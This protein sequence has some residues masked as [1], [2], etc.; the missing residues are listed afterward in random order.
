LFPADLLAERRTI[1]EQ[2]R[3]KLLSRFRAHGLLGTSGQG[4]IWLGLGAGADR[5]RLRAELLYDGTITAV[6]VEDLK[7]ERFVVTD[8]LSLI[9]QAELEVERG[10][11]PNGQPP[12]AAFLAPLDPL[13]W[14]RQVLRPLFGFDYVWEVYVP[15]AK[16]RWGYYVLP[17]WFGDR[18]VGRIEPR[19][20]RQAKALRVLGVWWEDGF[21][22]LGEEGFVEA[23]ADALDAHRRFG[24][25]KTV[26]LPRTGRLRAFMA[27][28]KTALGA[29]PPAG[30]PPVEGAA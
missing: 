16:R 3:H 4:E 28:V 2:R 24:D 9:D 19:I 1:D 11:P 10:V 5:P 30:R 20:D 13:V 22:P 21:D 27:A 12:G 15:A 18:F 23:F 26:V 17:I 6:A 14:D 8:E 29:L 7:G 25:V